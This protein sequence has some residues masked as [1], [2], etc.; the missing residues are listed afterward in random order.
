MG[1]NI[2][3]YVVAAGLV[4]AVVGVLAW[5]GGLSWFDRLPGDIRLIGENVRV[6]MPLTSMLL[7]S[8]VLSLA[9]TLLRR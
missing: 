6:Y 7:V 4:L 9:M 8:V 3:P 1:T 5:T 2:G